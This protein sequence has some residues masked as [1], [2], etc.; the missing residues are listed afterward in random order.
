QE[1]HALSEVLS[2][3]L[4]AV[5]RKSYQAEWDKAIE[6]EQQKGHAKIED[7]AFRVSG[8]ALW[9]A[10]E[11][12]KRMVF[13]GLDYLPPGAVS[14]ADFGRA[15]LASDQA[16]HPTDPQE[17]SWIREEFVRRGLVS[18][19]D[20]LKVRTNFKSAALANID[21]ERLVESDWAAYEFANRNRRLLQIP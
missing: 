3:A 12:F 16:S 14:F 18:H 9:I 17:R 13:R 1:P 15:I 4:Y 8:K 6:R 20:E 11:R 5:L 10:A 7:L 19:V 2:G 21:L